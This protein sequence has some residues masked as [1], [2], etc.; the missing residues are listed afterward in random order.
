MYKRLVVHNFHN[1]FQS[2][3][4]STFPITKEKSNW[5]YN[6]ISQYLT[7]TLGRLQS[8]K[9]WEKG[10]STT[11]IGEVEI[12]RKVQLTDLYHRFQGLGLK[13]LI[14][15]RDCPIV[16]VTTFHLFTKQTYK[17]ILLIHTSII[18]L[19]SKCN[20]SLSNKKFQI[21]RSYQRFHCRKLRKYS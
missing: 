12:K 18:K 1:P 9:K 3:I 20:L 11:H 19:F 16:L 5:E 14:Q 6:Q 17:A 4:L 8:Q 13:S 10:E 21:Y 7:H 15:T 2:A